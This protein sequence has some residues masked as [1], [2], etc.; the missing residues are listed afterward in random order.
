MSLQLFHALHVSCR[1]LDAELTGRRK[2]ASSHQP[3]F[4][5][6]WPHLFQPALD[7]RQRRARHLFATRFCTDTKGASAA[8]AILQR[9]TTSEMPSHSRWCSGLRRR[10]MT[11]VSPLFSMKVKASHEP[12]RWST[13]RSHQTVS[14][15]KT[16]PERT[17]NALITV[18]TNHPDR[19]YCSDK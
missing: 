3:A 14:C 12:P 19:E 5:W 9:H 6:C 16:S 15:H 4:L 18:Q 13:N 10:W 17:W 11:G 8:L 2:M 7:V 1:N